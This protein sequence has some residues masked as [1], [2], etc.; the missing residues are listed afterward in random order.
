MRNNNYDIAGIVF[1]FI[2]GIHCIITPIL[3]IN[4]PSLG[5]QFESPWLQSTLL[6]LIAGIFYQSVYKNFKRHKSKLTLGLGFSGFIILIYTYLTELLGEH[7]GHIEEAHHHQDETL[8]IAL[9]IIGSVLMISS[10]LF[11]I[12]HCKCIKQNQIN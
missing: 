10:H 4:F 2:C 1:S 7:H 5:E 6:I 3:I 9:A 12:K 11:N 8:T